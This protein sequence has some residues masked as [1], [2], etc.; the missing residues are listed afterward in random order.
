MSAAGHDTVDAK[1]DDAVVIGG[2]K[3][4]AIIPEG[5]WPACSVQR[6]SANSR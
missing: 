5:K 4:D 6:Q 2:A 3:H 1:G